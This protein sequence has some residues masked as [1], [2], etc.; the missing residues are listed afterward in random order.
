MRRSTIHY[1]QI[2]ESRF[3]CTE[4]GKENIMV[5][6]NR[7]NRRKTGHLKKLYCIYCK[8]ECNCAEVSYKNSY[9]YETFKEE[10]ECGRFVN[11]E[12]VPIDKLKSCNNTDC[13]LNHNGKCWR[14]NG[15]R[16]CEEVMTSD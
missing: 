1:Y 14:A 11:G 9:T 15:I 5:F 13:Y 6:R 10:F 8:K 16:P 3:F 7:G 4:C 2:S 12:R